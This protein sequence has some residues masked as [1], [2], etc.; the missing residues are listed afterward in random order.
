[1]SIAELVW[2]HLQMV[3]IALIL[4]ILLAW[5]IV[6]LTMFFP[7]F[8]AAI[9]TLLGIIYTIPSLALMAFLLPWLGLNQNVIIGAVVLYS[10]SILVRNILAA[11]DHLDPDLREAATAMG[12]SRWQQWWRVEFPLIFPTFWAAVRLTTIVAIATATL[13][14]KVN[15][16]GLGKLLFE[17]IQ[18]NRYDKIVMG[19]ILLAA[20]AIGFNVLFSRI[21]KRFFP[22]PYL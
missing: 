5:I 21:Q 20:L 1:M 16:G 18:T 22:T 2:Q 10:Q 14:A 7:L 8:K 4:S 19:S 11:L 3:S 9:V 13:G 6:A 17:G 12:M 15:A